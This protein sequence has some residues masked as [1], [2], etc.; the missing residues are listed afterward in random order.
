VKAL[1]AKE[2]LG[3]AQDGQLA[4]MLSKLEKGGELVK[5]S[6]RRKR[7]ETSGRRKPQEA[8]SVAGG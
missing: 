3:S 1:F 6:K 5:A 7:Q 8:D 2:T 4:A